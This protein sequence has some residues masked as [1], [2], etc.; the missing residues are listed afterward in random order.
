M[1]NRAPIESEEYRKMISGEECFFDIS[2][3]AEI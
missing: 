2:V 1:P 3:D